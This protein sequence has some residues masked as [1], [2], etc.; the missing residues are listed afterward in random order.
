MA[1]TRKPKTKVQKA[2]RAK[3]DAK[4]RT[5]NRPWWDRATDQDFFTPEVGS[6]TLLIREEPTERINNFG[7]PVVDILTNRGVFSTGAF[8]ILRPLAQI[9]K[10]GGQVAGKRLEFIATGE[11]QTRRYEEVR[12]K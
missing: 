8:A 1:G 5:D 3:K 11:G 12:V 10:Q 7:N 6:H 2:A 4:A 9:V